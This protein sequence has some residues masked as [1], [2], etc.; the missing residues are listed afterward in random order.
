MNKDKWT[1]D[2]IPDLSGKIIIIT[3]ANSGL[4]LETSKALA[5][6]GAEVIMACR[7]LEKA[8][9]AKKSVLGVVPNGKLHVAQ[10]DLMNLESIGK[11]AKEIRN[12]YQKL[13]VLINNAGIMMT[14]YQLT[15]DGFESQLGTNHLGH[16]ALTGQLIGLIKATPGS[17]VVNVSSMAHKRGD[18]DF[19]NLL[20]A[21]GKD[22]TSTRAYGRSKLANLLFTFELQRYFE[23][24][25]IDALAV[26]AH[27]GVSNTNLANHLAPK[28][29]LKLIMPLFS[30]MIQPAS[31]GALP[32]IRAASDPG[33]L[34]GQ[35]YGPDGKREFKGYPTL[36]NAVPAAHNLED[37]KRLWE[38]SSRLTGVNF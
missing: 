29:L 9:E 3:G 38:E 36:V 6:K 37:A 2:Q 19:D 22:Y 26:A 35:Y 15:S 17:R 11:F 10:L 1:T 8:E 16:F 18:M 13:D 7:S 23:K 20:F 32:Q 12:K 30:F 5:A 21:N 28:F 27:P 14:P 25:G 24:N 31:M 4:G 33:V 34:G